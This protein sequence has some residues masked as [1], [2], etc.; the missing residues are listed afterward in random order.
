MNEK[1]RSPEVRVI[2]REG[3]RERETAAEW[4]NVAA[5]AIILPDRADVRGE[6][7]FTASPFQRR[8]ERAFRRCNSD[9]RAA[10]VVVKN[11]C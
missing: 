5:L 10:L 11:K 6:P 7:A 3:Q 8:F 1:I 9:H 2:G 4:L